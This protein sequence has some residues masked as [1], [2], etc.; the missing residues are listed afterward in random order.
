[1]KKKTFIRIRMK[2]VFPSFINHLTYYHM[3]SDNGG[4]RQ[5]LLMLFSEAAT[6]K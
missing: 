3:L 5:L 1:M 4:L 6:L 2:V